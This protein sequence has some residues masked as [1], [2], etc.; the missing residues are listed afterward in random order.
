LTKA[1]TKES[2]PGIDDL[3]MKGMPD[4]EPAEDENENEG[5][6]SDDEKSYELPDLQFSDSDQ[7]T[8]LD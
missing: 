3:D 4:H 2:I 6:N 8:V 7:E 5:G 1:G